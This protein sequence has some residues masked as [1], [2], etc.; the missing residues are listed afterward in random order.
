MQHVLN[1]STQSL[2][3]L[4]MIIEVVL[5][6]PCVFRFVVVI[7]VVAVVVVAAV[8][9]VVVVIVVVAVIVIVV[10]ILTYP[11]RLNDD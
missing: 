8:D 6:K 5:C 10:S 2:H 4:L 9:V 7:V 1:L 11:A 3:L